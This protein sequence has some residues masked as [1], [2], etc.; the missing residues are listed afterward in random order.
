[1]EEQKIIENCPETSARPRPAAAYAPFPIDLRDRIALPITLLTGVV[2]S[3][4]ILKMEHDPELFLG[5]G[6]L[7]A[8]F[9]IG[10]GAAFLLLYGLLLWLCR[11]TAHASLK[12]AP[13]LYAVNLFLIL[14]FFRL[15]SEQ[16]GG[17]R[18]LCLWVLLLLHSLLLFGVHIQ[19]PVTARRLLGGVLRRGSAPFDGVGAMLAAAGFVPTRKACIA[20]GVLL[21][22]ATPA[23]MWMPWIILALLS[24]LS[25]DAGAVLA[26]LSLRTV[27]AI[28][29][30]CLGLLGGV[31]LYGWLYR[32]RHPRRL[33]AKPKPDQ[34]P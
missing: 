14:S 4:S 22:L 12:R 11:R 30:V 33:S 34:K 3:L 7:Y 21:L 25:P 2:F 26:F 19:P 18:F 27:Y 1:M 9:G 31:L 5:Y 29:D 24:G 16:L 32:L 17:V 28:H 10:V 23:I 20:A 8:D 6:E 13:W 15:P